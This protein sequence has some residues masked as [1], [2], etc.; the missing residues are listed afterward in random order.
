MEKKPSILMCS[1]VLVSYHTTALL[2]VC[3][4][5]FISRPF[6]FLLWFLSFPLFHSLTKL[7][8]CVVLHQVLLIDLFYSFDALS[9]KIS[10]RDYFFTS[11]AREF[12]FFPINRVCILFLSWY[13]TLRIRGSLLHLVSSFLDVQ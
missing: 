4:V 2:L 1:L 3:F 13:L 7:I 5:F 9:S 8:V 11:F 10:S 6:S 12:S